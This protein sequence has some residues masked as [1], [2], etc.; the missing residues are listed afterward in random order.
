MVE[1]YK[2]DAE[3]RIS[4]IAV[5]ISWGALAVTAGLHKGPSKGFLARS[6]SY[7]VDQAQN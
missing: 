2:D 5:V 4:G 3:E 6:R 7:A 1:S